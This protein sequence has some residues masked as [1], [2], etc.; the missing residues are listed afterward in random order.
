M[1]E[2]GYKRHFL[3]LLA[4]RSV[5]DI[6]RLQRFRGRFEASIFA[7]R[8]T[9]APTSATEAGA[10]RSASRGGTLSPIQFRPSQIALLIACK[11]MS[12]RPASRP[13]VGASASQALKG[14]RLAVR[15]SRW[16]SREP[17]FAIEG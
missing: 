3:G 13:L 11:S 6:V 17:A 4:D 2:A 5:S 8:K 12:V 14:S 9:T 10:K 1:A 16:P 7:E 15:I